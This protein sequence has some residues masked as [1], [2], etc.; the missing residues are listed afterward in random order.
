MIEPYHSY[1]YVDDPEFGAQCGGHT[2]LEDAGVFSTT[3][4]YAADELLGYLTTTTQHLTGQLPRLARRICRSASAD[5]RCICESRPRPAKGAFDHAG[6]DDSPGFSSSPP[7]RLSTP[8]STVRSPRRGNSAPIPM[9]GIACSS[10][11]V[12]LFPKCAKKSSSR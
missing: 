6:A 3:P 10:T 9:R 2:T 5:G 8:V 11:S 12:T 7:D 4:A 1:I